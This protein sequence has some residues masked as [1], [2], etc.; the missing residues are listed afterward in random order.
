MSVARGTGGWGGTTV[1]LGPTGTHLIQEWSVPDI[2][3]LMDFDFAVTDLYDEPVRGA[4]ITWHRLLGSIESDCVSGAATSDAGGRGIAPAIAPGRYRVTVDA[5][6]FVSKTVDTVHEWGRRSLSVRLLTPEEARKV[7][8]GSTVIDVCGPPPPNS[9]ATLVAASDAVVV[10]RIRR[11]QLDADVMFLVW[12]DY[13]NVLMPIHASAFLA[14][15]TTGVVAPMRRTREI[16]PVIA[17]RKGMPAAQ[18]LQA[19]KSA[20]K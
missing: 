13:Y 6:G 15:I 8:K 1:T 18:F 16:S 7:T 2:G 14:N 9:I 20:V 10:A 11:A 17:E 4:R 19:V 12:H 5:D 3:S